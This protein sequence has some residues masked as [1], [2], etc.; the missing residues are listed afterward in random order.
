MLAKSLQ[1]PHCD[2]IFA[3]SGNH[4]ECENCREP[5]FLARR[6]YGWEDL[7]AMKKIPRDLARGIVLGKQKAKEAA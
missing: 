6:G 7:V 1:C 5:A 3:G 4:L 2:L